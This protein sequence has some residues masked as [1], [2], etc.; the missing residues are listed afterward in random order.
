MDFFGMG[1]GEVLLILIVAL[2]IWGPEKI[3]EIARTLGRIVRTFKKATFDL[4]TAVTKEL[5]P[6]EKE[7]PPRSRAD[8]D[9][10]TKESSDT[11]TAESDSAE[12]TS[13]KDR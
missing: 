8:S 6:E 1:I 7:H 13:Q 2:I 4:T 11:D 9:D 10:K 5:S 12:A 3:P